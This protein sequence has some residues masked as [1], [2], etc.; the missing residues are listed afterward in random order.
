MIKLKA[1]LTDKEMHHIY[2]Y[3]YIIFFEVNTVNFV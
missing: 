3:I 1:V 2:I